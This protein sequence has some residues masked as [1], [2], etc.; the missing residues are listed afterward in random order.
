MGKYELLNAVDFSLCADN[1]FH[2]L[3]CS[4]MYSNRNYTK[5]TQ[6]KRT[7]L[8]TSLTAES[9]GNA[10]TLSFGP[11]K[12]ESNSR[13][14]DGEKGKNKYLMQKLILDQYFFSFLFF[15]CFKLPS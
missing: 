7:V 8:L 15:P 9:A 12:R 1:D 10:K 6:C 14:W 11:K 3:G 5:N 2:K 4:M 13:A